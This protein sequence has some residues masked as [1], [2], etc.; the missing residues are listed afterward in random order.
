M[1]KSISWITPTFFI[2]VD[3]QI[4]PYLSSF[5]D[6][7]W[8]IVGDNNVPPI[9][10]K[11]EKIAEYNNIKLEYYTIDGKWY[12]PTHFFKYKKLFSYVVRQSA[13][14]IY[15]DTSL[16]FWTYYAALLTLPRD[17]TVLAT[18]N[19]KTPKGARLE[20]FARYFM[21]QTLKHFRNFQVFSMNQRQ[22][23][24]SMVQGKNVLFAPL[25]LKDYGKKKER[26]KYKDKINF[27]AFGHIRQYKRLDLLIEAA[28]Q[29]YKEVKTPFMITIA[30]SC[31]QWK[32]YQ[33]LIKYPEIFDLQIR[34]IGDEEVSD[35]FSDA[36]Y[37]VL[38]YQDLAQSGAIT[39][40]FNYYVPVITSDILQFKEFVREGINGF[41]F[42]SENVDSL[43]D[44]MRYAL[45]IGKG[46][47]YQGL[48]ESTTEYVQNNFVLSAI[49]DKYIKYFDSF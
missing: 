11:L 46:D 23:L 18:H 34:F 32:E 9:Y 4:V 42:K 21:K 16:A 47:T 17:K 22:Y 30:G 8:I 6:I 24:E 40:A 19:V 7:H 20:H 12:D 14:I 5:Y 28:Q 45:Q 37:L 35:L 38:P 10:L 44:V 15:L 39:V 27:L 3:Y 33:S 36:D 1:K 13:D 43:K 48:I 41:M 26:L 29:L 49:A 2:D 31:S 25:T